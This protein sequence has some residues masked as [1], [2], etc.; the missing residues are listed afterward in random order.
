R[1]ILSLES[2]RVLTLGIRAAFLGA[3]L[4]FHSHPS[5]SSS[6]PSNSHNCY[7]HRQTLPSSPLLQI[8]PANYI[9]F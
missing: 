1:S 7:D 6:C 8:P 3:S 9:R 4:P 2:A 5:S